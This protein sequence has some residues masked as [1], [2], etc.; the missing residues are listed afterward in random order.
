MPGSGTKTCVTTTPGRPVDTPGAVGL[1]GKGVLGSLAKAATTGLGE[2]MATDR[3]SPPM[4]KVG[5]S[6][7]E[8]SRRANEN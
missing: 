5:T 3:N 2:S 1:P 7:P 8:L 4:P 6:K